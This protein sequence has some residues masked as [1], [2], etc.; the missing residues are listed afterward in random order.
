MNKPAIF[1]LAGALFAACSDDTAKIGVDVMPDG[2]KITTSAQH[3][4]L[5]TRTVQVDSVLANTS[6]SQ[7]G[8]IIDTEMRVRTT[9]DF[10]A[11]FHVPDNFILP[12]KELL[13]MEQPGVLK[14]DS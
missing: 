10:L 6:K 12:K 1:L 2:D 5:S 11:Q 7:L 8:S 3:F 4:N 9:C 13:Y 14:A